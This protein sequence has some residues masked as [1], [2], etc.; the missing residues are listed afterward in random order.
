LADFSGNDDKDDV[1]QEYKDAIE[2]DNSFKT[3]L[4]AR[5]LKIITY[6]A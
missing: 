3:L 4:Q 2:D 5:N 6:F 1:E